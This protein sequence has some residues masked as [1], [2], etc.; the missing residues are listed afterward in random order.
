MENVSCS[1]F[2]VKLN[3]HRNLHH[4]HTHTHTHAH[5][6]TNMYAPEAHIHRVQQ[7]N[8]HPS[9]P[10]SIISAV[11]GNNE[12]SVWDM[13]TATRRQMLWASPAQ[14]FTCMT[15]HVSALMDNKIIVVLNLIFKIFCLTYQL[16][17]QKFTLFIVMLKRLV[18]S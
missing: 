3:I 4:K 8:P 1:S 16:F 18:L 13:E 17:E 2:F 14:P 12:V 7:L 11:S 6:Q 15:D 9:Q 10:S 5:I